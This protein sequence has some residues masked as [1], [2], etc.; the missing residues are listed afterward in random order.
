MFIKNCYLKVTIKKLNYTN[1]LVSSN[2]FNQK[3]EIKNTIPFSDCKTIITIAVDSSSDSLL[4]ILFSD[5]EL[6]LIKNNITANWVDFSNVNLVW[7]SGTPTVR[8]TTG[9][10]ETKSNF[11][12]I[13]T[14]IKQTSGSN[15]NKLTEKLLNI[16]QVSDDN[17][18][19]FIF[20]A[21]Y[22]NNDYESTY[23]NIQ[24]LKQKG[25][26][27]FIIL[28]NVVKTEDLESLNPSNIF[29]WNFDTKCIPLIL[30]FFQNSL[31]CNN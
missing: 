28:G 16:P 2:C 12:Y 14:L 17:V 4:S 27:N 23:Q 21:Q 7:Y 15:L 30:Q 11:D 18:S 1:S 24:M 3:N 26:V 25:S 31:S 10:M 13:L 9:T 5:Y 6:N 19:T 29:Y 22:Y 8:M 20:I